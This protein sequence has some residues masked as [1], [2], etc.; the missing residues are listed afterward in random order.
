MKYNKFIRYLLLPCLLLL[1][2]CAL[3]QERITGKV[4]SETETPLQQVSVFISNTTTGTRTDAAGNFVLDK[5]PAGDVT[6]ILSYAGYEALEYTIPETLRGKTYLF[7]LQPQLNELEGVVV[8]RYDKDGW[9]KWGRLFT[10]A[11]IG[12]SAYAAQCTITNTDVLHFTYN[13]KTKLL[14][15]YASAPLQA[16]NK[17]LGY[18]ITVTL[19]DFWYNT[20]DQSLD[21]QAY[22]LFTELNGTEAEQLQWKQQREG[23]YQ[24][25]LLRFM[26]TLYQHNFKN[27]GY[28]VRVREQKPNAEKTRVQLLY[29]QA[30]E[31]VKDAAGPGAIN[32]VA[33]HRQAEKLF[34]RDS[35]QYYR[36]VLAQDDRSEN[37]HMELVNFKDIAQDTDS[38]TVLLHFTDYL[39]VTCS[40]IKEPLAYTHF[41]NRQ[42]HLSS[43][44]L[45]SLRTY[46][47]TE[48]QLTHN[49]PLEIKENGYFNNVDLLLT[50]F[51]GWWER[52]A[53]RLPY[54]YEP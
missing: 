2:A 30:F 17:A 47:V 10:E 20:A 28:Q 31:Q 9:K 22:N 8:G 53:T 29:R 48:L 38:S 23:V 3:C 44:E 32:Q 39:Q 51:W 7:K 54:D 15:A 37:L 18:H 12:G 24:Y 1:S 4:V 25:S 27:E 11:F 34:P 45:N 5:L 52:L 43:D 6:L 42:Y 21:Y 35:L 14:R 46:P 41:K 13:S 36:S 40:K 33:M 19:A 16:D 49:M 50:G 26:R